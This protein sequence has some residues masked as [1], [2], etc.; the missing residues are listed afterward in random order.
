MVM[1][2]NLNSKSE[3]LNKPKIQISQLDIWYDEC[4]AI[5]NLSLDIVSHEILGIIGPSNSG[6]T[7]FIK[8]LNRLNEL[9]PH[10]RIQGQIELD[11]QDIFSL[12][13]QLLRKRVG[14]VFALPL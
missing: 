8:T 11:G 7:S 3:I 12:N 10:A 2:E 13:V 6:K 1:K 14:V 5:K 4:Q 9:N